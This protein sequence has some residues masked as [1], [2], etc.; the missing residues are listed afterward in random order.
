MAS[1]MP[2]STEEHGRIAESSHLANMEFRV[3]A[4]VSLKRGLTPC[5]KPKVTVVPRQ[6]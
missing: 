2:V 3:A 4:K 6:H 1:F 5:Q